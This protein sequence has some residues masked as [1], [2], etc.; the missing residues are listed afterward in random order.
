LGLKKRLF[1]RWNRI[2][3]KET[4]LCNKNITIWDTN[5]ITPARLLIFIEGIPWWTP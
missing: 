2:S 5:E 3:E 1:G 4:N